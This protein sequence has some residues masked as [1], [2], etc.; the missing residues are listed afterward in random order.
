M[1][2][3]CVALVFMAEIFIGPSLAKFPAFP[4][5][6]TVDPTQLNFAITNQLLKFEINGYQFEFT[7]NFSSIPDPKVPNFFASLNPATPQNQI[8]FVGLTGSR[9]TEASSGETAI[10]FS[11][12]STRLPINFF[13]GTLL[14]PRNFTDD[15]ITAFF[16]DITQFDTLNLAEFQNGV[17]MGAPNASVISRDGVVG[18]S[19]FESELDGFRFIKIKGSQGADRLFGNAL[20]NRMQGNR[21]A[22][23]LMGVDGK[24]TLEGNAGNDILRGGTG[25][26]I[27]RGGHHNDI[28]QGEEGDDILRGDRG[29]DTLAG[30]GGRNT[31]TG[32]AGA[33]LFV[34][35]D[36]K[37]H[38]VIRD[39]NPREGDRI[40]P[41]LAEINVRNIAVSLK[42]QNQVTVT[43]PFKNGQG[44]VILFS[45][46][47]DVLRPNDKRSLLQNTTQRQLIRGWSLNPN[48]HQG[49]RKFGS[50]RAEQLK[51]TRYGD[52]LFGNNGNDKILGFKGSDRLFGGHGKDKLHGAAGADVLVGDQGDDILRGGDGKDQL[53]GGQ[54]TDSLYG[55]RG[56]DT[57]DGGDGK[58]LL[59]GGAG[60]NTLTGG[61][62]ADIFRFTQ[63]DGVIDRVTDFEVGLDQLDLRP[64]LQK[65]VKSS[66]LSNF[67]QITSPGPTEL[68]RFIAIDPNGLSGGQSY[69]PLLQIDDVT[70]AQLLDLQN[71]LI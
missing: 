63:L 36:E 1:G 61:R 38:T 59:I 13:F 54:G 14:D 26:D 44:K 47:S 2:D 68:T 56:N 42:P 51:G 29:S 62:Q 58:D 28:L 43:V 65:R 71:Y 60:G 16:G 7:G 17:S 48:R 55:D 25:R 69:T 3:R 12:A 11:G 66:T 35:S 6:S 70:D 21:G 27:L 22:D 53:F 33:D 19:S 30:D 49:D 57:L 37:N 9:V 52:T 34:L 15:I 18:V 64:I 20:N 10:G 4:D 40:D 8:P 46:Q 24:D 45:R 39:F 67:I 31:L 23:L 41:S 5:P 50:G 32:G